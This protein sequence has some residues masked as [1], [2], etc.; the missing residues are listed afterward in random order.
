MLI[1]VYDEKLFVYYG[2]LQLVVV[3][4]KVGSVCL[5]GVLVL[6]NDVMVVLDGVYV[7]I[8]MLKVLFLY[9]VIYQCFVNDVVVL[10][11]GSGCS[12]LVV[13]LLLVDCV[14][15]YG[16][17]EGLCDFD[18]CFIDLVMLVYVEVLDKGDW[19]VSVF[20]CDCVLMFKVLF[21]GMLV[22]IVCIVQCFEGIV[23]SVDLVVLFLYENDENCYWC[24][25]CIVDVDCFGQE[26]WLFWDLFSDEFYGD[27]GNLVFMCLF[28]GVSVVCQDGNYVF[29][30]GQGVLLQGDCLFLDC[31][32]LGLLKSECLFC[33]VVDVYEQ[34]FGFVGIIGCVLIWYQLVIDVLN[35]FI[36][37]LGECDVVVV[38]GEV[39]FV[40]ILAVLIQLIDLMLEVCQIQKCLVIYKCVDGVDLLFI[41]YMLLGYKEGQCVLVILYVYLVDFV[42]VVQVGQV[43]GLQQIFICLVL[44][45]LMLLVGYVIID[46]VLFLIVGDLKIVYDIYLEQLEVDVRVVVDKV[47]DMGVVDCNW[48]GVIGYSYGGLMIVNLIVYIDLFKVGVV[49]SGLYNKM[50]MLFGFQN[51]CWLVWQVQDVYLKVLLFFYVDRIKLL[52][53]LVYGEDDVNLGIELFQLCKLFQVICGNGGIICLVMLLYELYWYIVL[54]FN[55]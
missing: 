33:S 27:L 10:D 25:I 20:Y 2:Q 47:V 37:I 7:F 17:L 30:C 48:I 21:I 50:F 40:F 26:G 16:V 6:Y 44:Y 11:L 9:V 1:S 3:D 36:C 29:L 22:E 8:E 28:N 15:V 38:K 35:V 23:W 31:L 14:L 5:I 42:N 41:L 54:E 45:C 39:V 43:F 19:K 52:L 53:L 13:S 24:Q 49:I 32:D 55:E 46:N 34:V 4:V 18:W 51:E 12:M